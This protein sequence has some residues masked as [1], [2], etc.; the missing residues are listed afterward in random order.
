[1]IFARLRDQSFPEDLLLIPAYV[2]WFI[3]VGRLLTAARVRLVGKIQFR[4]TVK[5]LATAKESIYDAAMNQAAIAVEDRL[6]CAGWFAALKEAADVRS[7]AQQQAMLV[8]L[9]V[10]G[11]STIPGSNW[12]E[13]QAAREQAHSTY[14]ST[15]TS[16]GASWN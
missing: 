3:D 15:V 1:M 9:S 6:G 14:S 10:K 7:L 13:F 11:Q 8:W 5:L 2:N 12:N 4:E 16:L